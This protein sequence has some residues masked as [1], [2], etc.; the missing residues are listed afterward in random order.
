VSSARGI[1]LGL[2]L[3][4][5]ACGLGAPPTLAAVD[6]TWRL[7]QPSPP[8]PP[9]APESESRPPIGLGKIGDIEFWAPNRG[10]LITAGNP[11][12]IPPGL[13]AY[14]GRGWHELA[15]VCS[16]TDGRIAWAAP[17]E[18]W[19][20]SD[21]R[22]GQ[23]ESET[24][25]LPPLADNT[26]CR[27]AGGQVVA[28]YAHPAFQPDSYQALH[29]AGCITSTDCW[30]AGNPL[31]EPQIGAFQLHWNGGSLEAEPYPAEGHAVE[32]MRL[33]EGRLYESVRVAPG[34]RV[35]EEQL[36]VPAI[37]RINPEAVLPH[38]KS[39]AGLPLNG[40]EEP[41]QLDFL[42]LSVA[43]GALWAA[44]AGG[45][46]GGGQVTVLRDAEGGWSQLLGP[47][48]EP[49]GRALFPNEF[50][51]ALAAE[52]GTDS[53]WLALDS[54][55]DAREPSPTAT[56]LVA[57]ISA[58]G[59]VLEAQTLPT[60]G[61]VGARGA[62][63]KLACPAPNDCWLATTQGW[64]FHLAPKGEET[65]P[66]DTDPAFKGLITYRPP[67]QG[68][69]QVP[70]DAPPP[71]DSG[72]PEGPPPYGSLIEA[73][74]SAGEAKVPLPLLSHLHSRLVHGTT[75]ELRFRLAVKARVR[76]IA[77]RR[78]RVV[79]STPMRT[80]TAGNRRLLLRLDARRWPTKLDLQTHALAPLPTAVPHGEG[81]GPTT[82]ST[83]LF[84]LPRT[85]LLT[86]SGPLP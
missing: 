14:N 72:L 62:A 22:P 20:V 34:D 65:L 51:Q 16:A 11:P 1:A 2:G 66:E 32:D 64:L 52:P 6:V 33:F 17:D 69:A 85:P 56:A 55:S 7:E 83:G 81:A 79:A 38:F 41:N 27:F 10:L 63:A 46:G 67:D 3:A 39:E 57:R 37:H 43:A 77:K 36:E 18:F 61:G 74:K 71:D 73:P 23:V 75:L 28:S 9:G 44:A 50:V 68:L 60:V 24:G 26:L 13:W 84:V 86:R 42:H 19:T 48:T 78:R 15:T 21:G 70:L 47:G 5:V 25:G 49:S 4:I 82:V 12:T 40:G 53:A 58:A 31:P 76:L 45:Q 29:A 30:F 80:L 35:T 8:L 54:P 59:K